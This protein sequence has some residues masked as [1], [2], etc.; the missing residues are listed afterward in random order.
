MSTRWRR[1]R[2][3][4]DDW[5]ARLW[6]LPALAVLGAVVSGVLLPRVDVA[7]AGHLPEALTGYLFT[8]G[9]E[10]ARTV[11][12]VIA[13]SLITVTALTFSLTVVTLQLAASQFSPRLLRTFTRDP[14]VQA[15]L[16]LL[17]GTFTYAVVVLRTVRSDTET[18]P[19]FV[20][21]LSVTL[22]FLLGLIA[23]VALI[24]LLAHLVGQIRIEQL[25]QRVAT[26]STATT[27]RMLREHEHDNL[28]PA[29]APG[30]EP[31]AARRTGFLTAVDDTTLLA[32]AVDAAT[33]ISL[34]RHVGDW[35]IEG[36]PVA[37]AWPL[38]PAVA[39]D[40][41][42]DDL[43]AALDRALTIGP[44]RTADQDIA[45]GLRQ[46]TDV[47]VKAL[48]PGIN[49]PTTA[50]HALN[51]TSALLCDLASRSRSLSHRLLHDHDQ[52]LRVIIPQPD[53]PD[54]LDLALDQP[55]RYSSTEPEV[56][57]R[58]LTL[59]REVAWCTTDPHAHAAVHAQ[60]DQINATVSAQHHYH[61][62]EQARLRRLS[63][64]VRAAL[65][66]GWPAEH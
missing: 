50:V 4:L 45:F 43:A 44:E 3:A 28:P 48:S 35:L 7:L 62:T 25:L 41:A 37:H 57:A 16:A 20:P 21:Q 2:T 49:D 6:P 17:L 5:R 55:R 46:L 27:H 32:V 33:I 10:A 22:A 38:T 63:A 29:V 36:T 18:Q 19:G 34:D 23:V 11:L 66:G 53:L 56:Q 31:V 61:E 58:L 40:P 59:L 12:S 15:T 39:A 51:H 13:G 8:G 9:P 54:L 65:A 47:A 1:W 14:T 60:L 52:R 24:G 42:T 30:A 64:Q 26:E